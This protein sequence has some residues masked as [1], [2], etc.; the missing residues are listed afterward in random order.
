MNFP[1]NIQDYVKHY[2]NVFPKEF[3]K[4]TVDQLELV[5]WTTHQFYNSNQ[6][7]IYVGDD[8]QQSRARF[9]E[10]QLIEKE[11]W[12]LLYNYVVKN[13]SSYHEQFQWFNGWKGFTGIKFHKY[14]SDTNM[15][16]HCDHIH[17]LFDGEVKGV[18]I[19]TIVGLL[20]EDFEGGNF[21]LWDNENINLE[22]GSVVIFPS[23]FMYPHRVSTIKSGVRYS[24]VSW[25]W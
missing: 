24:F 20:N 21:L 23:N 16:L 9:N 2:K 18:P 5:D 15:K 13:F 11:I 3:C 19:L 10:Q 22:T 14:T 8:F 4:K 12:N 6:E 25:A 1:T 7:Y 17:D